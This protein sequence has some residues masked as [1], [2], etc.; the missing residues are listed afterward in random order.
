M[1][2]ALIQP[3]QETTTAAPLRRNRRLSPTDSIRLVVAMH[4]ALSLVAIWLFKYQLPFRSIIP[5]AWGDTH[6]ALYPKILFIFPATIGLFLSQC[7]ILAIWTV[8]ARSP[9]IVRLLCLTV[10]TPALIAVHFQV[11][12]Q[13]S[14]EGHFGGSWYLFISH[15]FDRQNTYEVWWFLRLPFSLMIVAAL[16]LSRIPRYMVKI[17]AGGLHLRIRRRKLQTSLAELFTWLTF[18]AACASVC[19][20]LDP[21]LWRQ[22]PRYF[23]DGW[24]LNDKESVI[25]ALLTCGTV[26]ILHR[27]RV[28]WRRV[29]LVAML[30]LGVWSFD[31]ATKGKWIA[32]DLHQQTPGS[33]ELIALVVFATVLS[34]SLHLLRRHFPVRG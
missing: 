12:D 29:A 23:T 13:V 27:V 31:T 4:A 18:V 9:M 33:Y 30:V 10:F 22:L 34:V 21:D 26:S 19:R 5:D 17:A 24:C 25:F 32:D 16:F 8:R 7:C 2:F 6:L 11:L 3:D 28:R 15:Q 14:V 1:R 20:K